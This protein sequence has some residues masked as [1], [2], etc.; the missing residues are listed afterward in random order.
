MRLLR[1]DPHQRKLAEL[2]L[3]SDCNRSELARLGSLMTKVTLPAG[4]V[5]ISEGACRATS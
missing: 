1:T 5:L 2:A 3:F 4:R